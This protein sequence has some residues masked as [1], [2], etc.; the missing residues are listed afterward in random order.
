VGGVISPDNVEEKLAD[1]A[2]EYDL[3]EDRLR[4]DGLSLREAADRGDLDEAAYWRTLLERH[5]VTPRPRDLTI[6]PYLRVDERMVA[7]VHGLTGQVRVGILSNDTPQMAAA[8]RRMYDPAAAL[9]PVVISAEVGLLKPEAAI[10][11]HAV[12]AAG[13]P[14]G[15]ALFID[16]RPHNVVGARAAGLQAVRFRGVEDLRR[17]LIAEFSLTV[18]D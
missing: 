9:S 1:L 10:Y 12:A 11:R 2:R 18:E 4:A 7:L 16:D 8:R 17:R 6:E 13:C 3:P 14:A 5:G 15:S